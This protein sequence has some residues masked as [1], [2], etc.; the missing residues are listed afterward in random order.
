MTRFAT[1]DEIDH[2]N[3]HIVRNPDGGNI[4]QSA[5]FGAQKAA[6][7]WTPRYIIDGKLAILVLEKFVIGSGN[8]WYLPKGPGV[9]TTKQLI[10][11]I[12][13]LR[14]FAARHGVFVIKV[15]PELPNDDK[16]KKTLKEN[17]FIGIH[18][19]Q[20]NRSTVLL[21]I[22][23]PLKKVLESLPQKG[24]HAIRRAER[25]GVT[26]VVVDTSDEYCE[27]MF[28]LMQ[29]TATDRFAIRHYDYYKS[30]W[31]HFGSTG[32]GAF[33]FAYFEG[34][35]VAA[36]Y[37]VVLGAKATYK[38]GASSRQKTAYGASHFLQ[39]K[40][41]EWAKKR[42]ATV[43]D[44]CG[45]PPA[46]QINNTSHVYY[47]IGRFKTSFNKEV[48][49]YVGAY[50]VVVKPFQYKVWTVLTEHVIGALYARVLH[51]YFY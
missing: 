42:G 43:Y 7:G 21:D 45:A 27:A 9:A 37:V 18:P 26:T 3:E 5:E 13:S 11:A 40:A 39:W 35:L 15:E 50:D 33:H 20:P 28:A 6:F 4:F 47:G 17:A 48:T 14:V 12:A 29:E 38:D 41:I 49:E 32:V 8:I 25:D 1:A 16:I 10:K 31:Q 24:R 19:I 34:T 44:F 22:S 2:W 36:A 23:R 46:D 30:F 51:R